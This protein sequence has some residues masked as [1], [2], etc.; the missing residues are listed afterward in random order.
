MDN[1]IR[2]KIDLLIK[3]YHCLETCEKDIISAYEMMEKA[4]EGGH[5]LIIAGNGGSAADSEH[6]VG[7]LMKSF[8]TKRPVPSQLADK[9]RTIDSVR[10]PQLAESLEMGLRAISLT[11]HPALS[12]AFINDVNG[13][14]VFAQQLLGYGKSGDVFLGISTSGN[15]RNVMNAAVVAKAMGIPII[16]L[17]GEGGGELGGFADVSVRVPETETY[18]VQELHLPIYHCWCLMLE[19]RFFGECSG[20]A[21]EEEK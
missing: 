18:M 16:G 14:F 2:E 5:K 12:T 13:E 1:L 19:E 4:Y 20:K 11:N 9:M 10:G 15:S 3:R 8:K 21:A 17:T 7:E 6:I